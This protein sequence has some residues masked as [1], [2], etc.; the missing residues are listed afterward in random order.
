MVASQWLVGLPTRNCSG[1]AC[2]PFVTSAGLHGQR[3]ALPSRLEN[4]FSLLLG[5][6][7][8]GG[9]TL[10]LWPFWLYCHRWSVFHFE[11]DLGNEPFMLP[12]WLGHCGCR[13]GLAPSELLFLGLCLALSP[14]NPNQYQ[15][16]PWGFQWCANSETCCLEQ[17]IYAVVHGLTWAVIA[18][19]AWDLLIQS[20]ACYS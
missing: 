13:S 4:P 10:P 19:Q 7:Q 9:F 2:E 16:M 5:P 3:R 18:K 17:W 8:C 1:S 15:A 12:L 6:K 20:S 14:E 11:L